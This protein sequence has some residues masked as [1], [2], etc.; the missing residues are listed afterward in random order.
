RLRH[1]G[2]I[3]KGNAIPILV[4][5]VLRVSAAVGPTNPG[6]AQDHRR[7]ERAGEASYRTH[8]LSFA[9]PIPAPR[10]CGATEIPWPA[11]SPLPHVDGSVRA[12]QPRL[13]RDQY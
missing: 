10:P 8:T 4:D 5:P 13:A 9:P 1:S 2:R 6:R 12:R 7:P 3:A 11:P